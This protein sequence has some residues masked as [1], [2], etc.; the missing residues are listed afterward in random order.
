MR[1]APSRAGLK[2]L[3][4]IYNGGT[5]VLGLMPEKAIK[6]LA[7]DNAEVPCRAPTPLT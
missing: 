3:C 6:A 1:E 2:V 5:V 7:V 4:A